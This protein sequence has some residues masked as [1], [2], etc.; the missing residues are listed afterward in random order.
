MWLLKILVKT[1]LP[2]EKMKI[3]V[4]KEMGKEA[5]NLAAFLCKFAPERI[6]EVTKVMKAFN[7][8][9]LCM[10][11]KALKSDRSRSQENYY[12]KWCDG[13]AKYC[14]LTS[15]EMHDE[16]L[17]LVFGEETVDTKFGPKR[18]P[19]K[20]SGETSK[21]TYS[22]LIDTLILKSTE[23]GY[24]VPLST[25]FKNALHLAYYQPGMIDKKK[26]IK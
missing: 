14:G 24:E 18:R 20:R 4:D 16:M 22:D 3:R 10:E 12:R 15:A 7:D 9:G 23:M 21:D 2:D 17:M 6:A 13:F 19:L 25:E 11:V 1:R 8:R 5:A 26:L